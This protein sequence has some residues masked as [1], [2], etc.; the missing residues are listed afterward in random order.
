MVAVCWRDVGWIMG[1]TCPKLSVESCF[2]LQFSNLIDTWFWVSW[3]HSGGAEYR[4]KAVSKLLVHPGFVAGS[5]RELRSVRGEN[6]A[7]VRD[8]NVV[9]LCTYPLCYASFLVQFSDLK[10]VFPPQVAHQTKPLISSSCHVYHHQQ[11][12]WCKVWWQK[13]AAFSYVP[14]LLFVKGRIRAAHPKLARKISTCWNS[15]QVCLAQLPQTWV[16]AVRR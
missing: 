13:E 2:S 11:S 9:S 14:L 3:A 1:Q 15:L 10:S 7:R 8:G 6:G 12:R 16:W 5:A 4:G